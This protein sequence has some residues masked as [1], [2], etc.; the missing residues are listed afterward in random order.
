MP[1]AISWR[2]H[3]KDYTIYLEFFYLDI[4][5][6]LE[7]KFIG[8]ERGIATDSVENFNSLQCIIYVFQ[9]IRKYA[10]LI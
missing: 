1:P 5:I 8:I 6:I 9:I 7:K 4:P 3:K 2:G 10:N